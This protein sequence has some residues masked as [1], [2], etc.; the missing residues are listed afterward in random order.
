MKRAYCRLVLIPYLPRSQ[1][2]RA[3]LRRRPL[4][5]GIPPVSFLSDGRP[6]IGEGDGPRNHRAAVHRLDSYISRPIYCSSPSGVGATVCRR[7]QSI[8]SFC[9]WPEETDVEL[10]RLLFLLLLVAGGDSAR[11]ILLLQKTS[12]EFFRLKSSVRL[13]RVLSCPCDW[14]SSLGV[15]SMAELVVGALRVLPRSFG[16]S[17][18]EAE[19][20]GWRVNLKRSTAEVLFSRISCSLPFS[21]HLFICFG[22]IGGFKILSDA[23]SPWRRSSFSV[24]RWEMT[25]RDRVVICVFLRVVSA[26]LRCT[27]LSFN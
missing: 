21:V 15:T 26:K 23:R 27:V 22:L 5:A 7:S 10:L 9:G 2:K 20:G 17:R 11:R 14:I 12:G 8:D 16:S 3:N 19:D 1:A 18:V 25:C 24:W 6:A 13:G 4:P